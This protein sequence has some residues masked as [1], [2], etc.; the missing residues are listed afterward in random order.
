[1]RV[2]RSSSML[3]C[4]M[5]ALADGTRMVWTS[6]CNNCLVSLTL[7]SRLSRCNVRISVLQTSICVFH[8]YLYSAISSACHWASWCYCCLPC[9]FSTR[10]CHV[11]N[12]PFSVRFDVVASLS[13]S[14]FLR[15]PF[16]RLPKAISISSV[17]VSGPVRGSFFFWM[18]M[19]V[20][21][22]F[23]VYCWCWSIILSICLLFRMNCFHSSEWFTLVW[24]PSD[25]L[26]KF[27]RD[28]LSP[29]ALIVGIR[30]FRPTSGSLVFQL[31]GA[32][33]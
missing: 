10:P 15:H 12:R 31:G 14:C 17:F 26:E 1:M 4:F 7:L 13:L 5:W 3:L 11:N 23:F 24:C 29:R 16:F 20:D 9:S 32:N 25:V 22:I 18:L 28:F 30:E 6:F 2:L 8:V 19:L 33:L 27:E 21:C